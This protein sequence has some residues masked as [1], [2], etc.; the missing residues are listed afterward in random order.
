MCSVPQL[1]DHNPRV[2]DGGDPKI[3][4][5]SAKWKCGV[6]TTHILWDELSHTMSHRNQVLELILAPPGDQ[7]V[8]NDGIG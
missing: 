7:T 5:Y 2:G 4:T 8:S 6:K 1:G 3:Q